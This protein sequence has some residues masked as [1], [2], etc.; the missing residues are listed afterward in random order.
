MWKEKLRGLNLVLK[1]TTHDEIGNS[2]DAYS[3]PEEGYI[4]IENFIENEIIG[5]GNE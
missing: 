2:L 1:I 4:V 3:S 5:K